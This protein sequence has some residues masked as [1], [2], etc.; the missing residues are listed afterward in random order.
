MGQQQPA[1]L[2]WLHGE[3]H[4]E[5]EGHVQRKHSG[6]PLGGIRI[7]VAHQGLNDLLGHL[8]LH[9]VHRKR[10][11]ERLGRHRP[12]GKRHTV[13][14]RH[15]HR[16]TYPAARCVFTL[17][18]PEPRIRRQT[19]RRK[20]FPEPLHKRRIGEG[21]RARRVIPDFRFG[22]AFRQLLFLRRAPAPAAA[23]AA[24][25]RHF[26]LTLLEGAQHH[27]R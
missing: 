3:P 22:F 15:R 2:L 27:E 21:H 18:V 6:I 23:A 24:A 25:R 5:L 12:D 26:E 17:Y 13:T 20:P 1:G 10:I 7:L 19:C 9:E 8:V 14:C 16:L 11:P 4:P